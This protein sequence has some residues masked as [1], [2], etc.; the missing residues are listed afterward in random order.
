MPSYGFICG[1][2]HSGTSLLA[3]ILASHP[4]VFIPL[5]ETETFLVPEATPARWAALQADFAASGRPHLAEKTPR[6]LLHLDRIRAAAPGARFVILVRDG[7]DVAASFIKRY[8]SARPGIE[9]WLAD[10][11]VTLAERDAPDVTLLRYEDFLD[12]PASELERVCR[13]L[14]LRYRLDLLDYHKTPR[15]WFGVTEVKRSSGRNGLSHR[16]L[17]SWQINQPLFDGRG[18]WRELLG[19]DEK[20]A[21]AAGEGRLMLERLGYEP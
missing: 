21:F 8:G 20:A 3:N 7:R 15:L 12:D 16:Q 17:R 18:K 2:G 5:R 10:N 9:R 11:R 4:E 1:C 19:P 14:G 6:H 13:F